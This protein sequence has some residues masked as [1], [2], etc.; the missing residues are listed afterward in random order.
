[1]K[2]LSLIA[3]ALGALVLGANTAHSQM[4][5]TTTLQSNNGG[6]VG[7]I[8]YFDLKAKSSIR[9]TDLETNYSAPSNTPVGVQ[10][11]TAPST[12]V[13]KEGNASLWKQVGVDDGKAVSA[14]RNVATKIKLKT[15]VVLAAGSYAVALIAVGS[16]HAYTTGTGTNQSYK[17]SFISL[18]LGAAANTPWSRFPF[19]PRVWNGSIIYTSGSGLFSSFNAVPTSGK[20]PLQVKF[21]DT[22]Y[23]SSAGGVKTWAWD[24]DGDNKIDSTVQNPSYTYTATGFDKKFSVTLTT[25]DG[26]H[27]PSK[28]TMKDLITVNPSKAMAEDFGKGT[29]NKPVPSP[30]VM[31]KNSSHYIYAHTRGFHFQAPGLF[32]ANGFECPND[33]ATKQT[34]QTVS[35][36][37]LKA[38]PATF[39]ATHTPTAAELV[40]HGTGKAGTILRPKSPILFKKGE[41]LAILG[42]CHSGAA[43]KN[44]NS[45]GQGGWKTSVLNQP[46]TCNRLIMQVDHKVNKGLGPIA[47]N[48]TGSIGRVWVHVLGN[49][50]TLVPELTSSARPILGTTSNLLFKGNLATAQAGVIFL[51]VGRMPVP[52]PTPFGSLLIKP[53]FLMNIAIPGGNGTLPVPIPN[54]N[55]LKGV[56]LDWQGL[57]FDIPAGIYGMSNGTEWNLGTK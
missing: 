54:S 53:P 1:M 47:D 39:P 44:Y 17:D 50:S 49:T 9:I 22:T 57:V 42:A 4:K 6:S 40:F 29:F 35:V 5:L 21:T 12:Y 25:T 7:G 31:P 14:G 26:T 23:T 45:Y 52:I 37:R 36:Y 27:P 2:N 51:G 55:S 15:P 46:I 13:G 11:W 48:G 43:G 33:H 56:V 41:H 30:I 34:D 19:S 8:V 18:S 28:I 38:A 16:G 32:L 20:S 10:V 24:F 3:G